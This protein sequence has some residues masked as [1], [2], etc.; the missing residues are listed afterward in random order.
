M[1]ETS[2]LEDVLRDLGEGIN[3]VK[4]AASKGATNEQL[5]GI[6]EHM[7]RP[8]VIHDFRGCKDNLKGEQPM[9]VLMC[10]MQA[11]GKTRKEIA[12]ATGYTVFQ[13]SLICRQPWFRSRFLDIVKE[14]GTDAVEAFVKGETMN[15]LSTL[16]EIRDDSK[17]PGAT[18]RQAACDILDRALGKPAVYVKTDNSHTLSSA[19]TSKEEIERQLAATYSQLNSRGLPV[20]GNTGRS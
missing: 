11:A 17:T 13:V 20:P 16:V 7:S 4:K 15:S 2:S 10:Y 12:E 6:A 1:N 8:D 3:V 9:H 5:E 14:A 18:R 19:T